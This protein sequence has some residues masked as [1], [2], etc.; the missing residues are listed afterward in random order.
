MVCPSGALSGAAAL[1]HAPQR[2]TCGRGNEACRYPFLCTV[3][4][5]DVQVVNI[6]SGY[7]LP[8]QSS[9]AI[10]VL[11]YFYSHYLFA[12]GAAHIGAMYTAFLSVAIACGTPGLLAAIALGQVQPLPPGN[13][14]PIGLRSLRSD[15]V[16]ALQPGICTVVM[17]PGSQIM[18]VH[19][20]DMILLGSN[21]TAQNYNFRLIYGSPS[22]TKY[23][24]QT[25]K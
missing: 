12:S 11:L 5:H 23:C 8:W 17:A 1:L 3:L 13:V 20:V 6:V 22:L 7:G 25:A 14:S 21:I 2:C 16:G 4:V 19:E 15:A 24:S 10:I 18:Q 9:F